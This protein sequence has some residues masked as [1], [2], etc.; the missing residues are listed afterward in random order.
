MLLLWSTLCLYG[1]GL[2][3]FLGFTI[4]PPTF[5]FRFSLPLVVFAI[6]FSIVFMSILLTILLLISSSQ[7][8]LFQ[9]SPEL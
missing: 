2:L 3:L 7:A 9:L 8:T 6:D 4:E 5:I 1:P